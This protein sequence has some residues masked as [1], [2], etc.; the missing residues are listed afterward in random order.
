MTL[1]VVAGMSFQH[2]IANDL[3]SADGCGVEY[4]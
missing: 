4:D 1:L 2:T 3:V